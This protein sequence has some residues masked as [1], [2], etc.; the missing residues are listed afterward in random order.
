MSDNLNLKGKERVQEKEFP[1]E[2][3]E[4]ID[5]EKQIDMGDEV[6]RRLIENRKGWVTISRILTF[7]FPDCLLHRCLGNSERVQ[8]WREKVAILIIMTV[9]NLSFLA[10]YILTPMYACKQPHEYRWEEIHEKYYDRP[11]VVIDGYI[12]DLKELIPIHP[13]SPRLV[14]DSIGF[15]ISGYFYRRPRNQVPLECAFTN[16]S[17][18]E[19]LGYEQIRC[20]GYQFRELESRNE[21]ETTGYCHTY[22]DPPLSRYYHG[23]IVYTWEDLVLLNR[24]QHW[25]VINGIVYNTTDYING[26]YHFLDPMYE[27]VIFDRDK[28]D[29]TGL[30]Y[31]FFKNDRYLKCF[32]ALFYAGKI[33]KRSFLSCF[34]V[35]VILF[36]FLVLVAVIVGVKF[37]MA[38]PSIGVICDDL[39][40]E[41]YVIINIPCYKE[42]L[43]LMEK[44]IKAVAES[45]YPNT[46]K[47]L[48][49]VCDGMVTGKGNSQSTPALVLEIFGRTLDECSSV[50]SYSSLRG[51]NS[52]KVYAGYYKE[53]P[54]VVVVK[55]G[56]KGESGDTGNRGKRDSQ[57]ILLSFLNKLFYNSTS[58]DKRNFRRYNELEQR[59]FEIIEE[60]F[61]I[62]PRVY[63]YFV[64]IDADTHIE[65]SS[66]SNMVYSME[67][68]RKKVI[69]LCG[70]TRPENKWDSWVTAIQVY[71]YW[72]SYNLNKAFES[73]FGGVSCLPGCFS[74][75]RIKFVSHRHPNEL[76]KPGII[77]DRILTAYANRNVNNLHTKN[78]LH[79]GEDRYLTSLI[80]RF[81]P[82]LKTQYLPEAKCTTIVP[83]SWSVL[84]SQRRR[85]IN[86]TIHNLIELLNIPIL[87]GCGPFS[88]KPIFL[89]E[90]ISTFLLPA[91]VLYLGYLFYSIFSDEIRFPL[92]LIVSSSVILGSQLILIIIKRAY[93]YLFWFVI[94]MLSLPIWFFIIPIYA[95]AHMDH[96]S[97]GST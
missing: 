73:C 88:V 39:E 75:F 37:I 11:W 55:C 42:G 28:E 41:R 29:A 74:I 57:I 12:L 47:L 24:E 45:T 1:V 72:I 71:E 54:Y 95:V 78:L 53:M 5:L 94:Y 82:Y 9:L 4:D 48:I 79:L 51:D 32:D 64:S 97:W 18:L 83:R 84:L 62:D 63:E 27:A 85:W 14:Q 91:S 44:T 81:F 31:Y 13:G 68:G 10:L 15:D 35:N 60:T 89:I 49:V 87:R 7:Y 93:S 22:V 17:D 2:S 25:L 58:L 23:K 92:I 59:L 69:A 80:L 96:F 50:Y 61:K 86:S 26:D 77:D 8:A 43:D 30:Y 65:P 36:S 67:K 70:E 3:A 38:L 16:E 66:L 46:H 76:Q 56:K 90:L 52:A 21:T 34:V 20:T 19:Y 33:D 6:E 40:E